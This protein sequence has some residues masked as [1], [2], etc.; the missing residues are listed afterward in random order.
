MDRTTKEITTPS[1][2]KIVL[3]D[4]LTAREMLPIL[5]TGSPT[6]TQ[7]DSI[8]KALQMIQA[9]VVSV[10]GSTENILDTIQD[11]PMSDYLFITKEV[12][13]LTDFQTTKN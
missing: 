2:H 11:Y 1:G 9:A 5:K 6:P 13:G 4:Y 7:A 12:A 8:D 3:K 10:D